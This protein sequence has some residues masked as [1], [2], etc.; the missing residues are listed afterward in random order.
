MYEGEHLSEYQLQ[1]RILALQNILVDYGEKSQS[2]IKWPDRKEVR[3]ITT[4]GA[5][6]FKNGNSKEL[7]LLKELFN[8][9]QIKASLGI[10]IGRTANEAEIHAKEALGKASINKPS[11]FLVDNDG[12]VH[13]PIG[14]EVQLSYSIRVDNQKVLNIA[15]RANMSGSVI[16]RLLSFCEIHGK[17][18][19]TA[20]ELADGFGITPRSAR[21]ILIRLEQVGL[22]A[23]T[24][25]EQPINRGRPRQIY[26]ILLN[27]KI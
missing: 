20:A 18:T 2:I 22:A 17:M 10:G 13:G 21:R 11:C 24:G 7:K 15:K 14:N 5:L 12:A 23:V 4:R 6:Q 27:K 8:K 25:E 16:N 26:S 1:R 19:F 3:F 9:T